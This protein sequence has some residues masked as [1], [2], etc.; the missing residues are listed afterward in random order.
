MVFSHKKV[1]NYYYHSLFN[2]HLHFKLNY[3]YSN[4][5]N[6]QPNSCNM[7]NNDLNLNFLYDLKQHKDQT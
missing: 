6:N 3:R 1:N 5:I 2:L 4:T 7:N